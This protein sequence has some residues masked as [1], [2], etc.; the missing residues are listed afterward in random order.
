MSTTFLPS[1]RQIRGLALAVVV[2][3]SGCGGPDEDALTD[4]GELATSA[5]ALAPGAVPTVQPAGPVQIRVAQAP[6][7]MAGAVPPSYGLMAPQHD[8]NP[9]GTGSDTSP[10]PIP[11]RGGDGTPDSPAVTTATSGTRAN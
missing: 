5:S 6:L 7:G 2:V 10:D 8:P 9:V 1:T 3:L 4:G 11:A